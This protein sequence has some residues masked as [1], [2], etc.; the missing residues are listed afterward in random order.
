MANIDPQLYEAAMIDGA[1]KWQQIR[2]ITLPGIS[3]VVVLLLIFQIGNLL[4]AGFEQILLLYSPSVYSVA[5]VIDTYVY[6]SGLLSMQYSYATAVGFFK[7]VSAMLLLLLA[8]GMA[9][10]LGHSGLW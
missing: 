5:D 10:R 1:N 3:F 2:A 6:R 7:S 8:H 9:R 4:N